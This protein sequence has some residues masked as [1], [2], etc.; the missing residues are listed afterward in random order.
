M[1]IL[2]GLIIIVMLTAPVSALEL[3]APEVPDEVKI[4]MPSATEDFGTGMLEVLKQGIGFLRPDLREASAVCVGILASVMLIS[5]LKS[6]P[7]ESLKTVEFAGAA[8][9]SLLLTESSGS[10]INLGAQTVREIGEYGKLLLP[11][12]TGAMASQGGITA[13]VAIY[14]GTVVFSTLLTNLIIKLLIP[15]SYFYLAVSIGTSVVEGELLK[16]LRD[17][18]KSFMIWCL[19]T[20]LY[21][22]TGYI[23]ITGVISGTTD[24]ATLKVAKMTISGAVPVVG[25]ILSDASEAVLVSAGLVKNAAGLYGLFA[26]IALWIRPFVKIGVHYLLLKGTAAFCRVFGT[27]KTTDLIGDYSSVMGFLLAMTGSVSLM[28]IISTTCFM[29]G[30]G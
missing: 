15:M 4:Y 12:M 21:I 6:L 29:K 11:V 30:V 16:Q 17:G 28:L 10:M 27:K 26:I 5:I 13:S 18:I 9:I 3:V 2:S 22:F 23:G 25:G 1:R 7:G 19:K 24:A 14:S 20:I 8:A